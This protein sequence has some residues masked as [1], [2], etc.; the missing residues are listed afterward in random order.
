MAGKAS[1]LLLAVLAPLALVLGAPSPPQVVRAWLD[2]PGLCP[3]FTQT[4]ALVVD[5]LPGWYLQ[6]PR[7]PWPEL[8]GTSLEV[9]AGEGLIVGEVS[10]PPPRLKRLPL[11]G[12]V[13]PVYEGQLRLEFPLTAAVHTAPVDLPLR[14]RLTYQACSGE[15]CLRPTTLEL[16]GT[17]QVNPAPPE[18][19]AIMSEVWNYYR[20]LGE[21]YLRC[22]FQLVIR[23]EGEEERDT[24]EMEL[25]W[26]PPLARVDVVVDPEAAPREEVPLPV[27]YV[28]RPDLGFQF[29][30]Y[31]DGSW[32][33]APLLPEEEV[34]L[35]PGYHPE[36]Q[37]RAIS[38]GEFSGRP[39][40]LAEG[41]VAAGITIVYMVDRESKHL[42]QSSTQ[43]SPPGMGVESS[44]TFTVEE[45]RPGVEAPQDVFAVPDPE[46]V[47]N[48]PDLASHRSSPEAEA[49]VER[50]W[51]AYGEPGSFYVCKQVLT[52]GPGGDEG[53]VHIWYQDPFLRE[54]H[55]WLGRQVHLVIW[56]L[57][58]GV[59]WWH[60]PEEGWWRTP[61]VAMED[62]QVRWRF[63]LSR[64]VGLPPDAAYQEVEITEEPFTQ[65][66]AWLIRGRVGLDR[67]E[68]WLDANT[69][70]VL[71][72]RRER[73]GWEV[74]EEPEVE[75]YRIREFS[76]PSEIPPEKFTLPQ[77]VADQV[78][79]KLSVSGLALE[80]TPYSPERLAEAKQQ[81]QPVI[82]YFT[83]DWCPPCSWLE[84][85][86]FRH[87][88]VVAQAQRFLLLK[89]DLSSPD[90]QTQAWEEEYGV[91]VLPTLIFLSAG[92]EEVTRVAGFQT[93]EEL[94]AL[95]GEFFPEH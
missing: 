50:A 52:G 84:Q 95:L 79:E 65:R 48:A 89:V 94:L 13:L 28:T 18:A 76:R 16:S 40:W 55:R 21:F 12:A 85:H 36:V 44:I 31:P 49:K 75:F 10:Y 26:A 71:A 58:Q 7:P 56:D 54:E 88:E 60:T 29:R 34:P 57:R 6:A 24:A 17:V 27:S 42:L 25:W 41:Q 91:W 47:P 63:A 14:V 37:Y 45:F 59:A 35:H 61:E 66:P 68:L 62:P 4:A 46:A 73:W 2:L 90:Q 33:K 92:G 51:A 30:R 53:A 83:A 72:Y 23:A 3:N 19:A 82:I 64:A 86:T 22:A 5:I 11:F 15:V 69:Y 67:L 93:P 39:V 38:P 74:A 1:G 80:W 32:D 78:P 43:T 8:V 20:A 77:G 70:Q 9:Q 81:G 87:P